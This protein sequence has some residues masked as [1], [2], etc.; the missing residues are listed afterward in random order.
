MSVSQNY[1]PEVPP[2]TGSKTKITV[3][4]LTV[5]KMTTNICDIAVKREQKQP[6]PSPSLASAYA[7]FENK[8]KG[9]F[10]PARG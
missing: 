6:H 9:P 7:C 1:L 4:N 3:R 2:A 10:S 5:R 8:P